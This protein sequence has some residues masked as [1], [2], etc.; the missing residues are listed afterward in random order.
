MSNSCLK[1]S[2]SSAIIR[3]SLQATNQFVVAMLVLPRGR[4]LGGR[5]YTVLM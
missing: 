1:S 4:E 3:D 2:C 5:T